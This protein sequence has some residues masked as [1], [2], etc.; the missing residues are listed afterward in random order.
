MKQNFTLR[1]HAKR[2]LAQQVTDTFHNWQ[3]NG[4]ERSYQT[5]FDY[6]INNSTKWKEDKFYKE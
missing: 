3:Q 1:L 6:I 4:F 5:I 2:N